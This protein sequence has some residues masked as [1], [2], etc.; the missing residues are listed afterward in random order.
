MNDLVSNNLMSLNIGRIASRKKPGH[1]SLKMSSKNLILLEVQGN[2]KH[3]PS[4]FNTL[5]QRLNKLLL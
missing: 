1:F 4:F 2:Q 5:L 3:T